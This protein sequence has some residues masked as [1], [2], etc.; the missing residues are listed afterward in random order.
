M[1]KVIRFLER[2]NNS[3]FMIYH[4]FHAMIKFFNRKYGSNITNFEIFWNCYFNFHKNFKIGDIGSTFSVRK[5]ENDMKLN[6]KLQKQN[7]FF[8]LKMLLLFPNLV[9]KYQNW[10]KW[11][12]SKFRSQQHLKFLKLA[13][14]DF[15]LWETGIR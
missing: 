6:K 9:S 1:E 5:L 7:S 3:V 11:K 12:W 13:K 4:W 8:F 14:C 15:N 2:R 10:R